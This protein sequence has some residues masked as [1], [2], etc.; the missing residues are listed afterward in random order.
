MHDRIPYTY[1]IAWSDHNIWYYGVRYAKHCCPEDLF[2]PYKTSSKYVKNFIT[3]FGLPDVIQVRK[4]FESVVT[5]KNFE[6]KVLRRMKVN[7]RTDCLNMKADSFKNLDITKV[8]HYS[9][10]DN[11]IHKTLLTEE[12]R[13]A[14]S[15]S[16]SAGTKLGHLKSTKYKESQIKNKER[17]LSNENPGKNK[18][19]VTLENMSIAQKKRMEIIENRPIGSKNGMFGKHQSE[20]FKKERS[21]TSKA[22][23]ASEV[24]LC[25]ICQ[26]TIKTTANF[27]KHLRVTH[28]TDED[29]IR[30]LCVDSRQ[31]TS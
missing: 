3:E 2:N 20:Q 26:R 12:G 22:L 30:I 23:R 25:P 29:V 1:L 11:P 10:K 13:I 5:A 19:T 6:D 24:Y 27:Q 31:Q 28:K 16:V 8:R 7:L 17:M 21:I 15:K 9:G 14:F 18:S 4:T